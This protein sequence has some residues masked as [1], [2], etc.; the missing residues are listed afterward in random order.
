MCNLIERDIKGRLLGVARRL[1]GG[2]PQEN[3][4]ES[5]VLRHSTK[6]PTQI[7]KIKNNKNEKF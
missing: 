5:A 4:S 7:S 6:A 2:Y 3:A 1:S